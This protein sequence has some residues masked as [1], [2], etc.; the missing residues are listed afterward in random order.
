VE[1]ALKTAV[2]HEQIFRLGIGGHA[3]TMLAGVNALLVFWT[4]A[5]LVTFEWA[6]EVAVAKSH[7]ASLGEGW[8]WA[9]TLAMLMPPMIGLAGINRTT[10][11]WSAVL[12]MFAFA[13]FLLFGG[14]MTGRSVAPI[15]VEVAASFALLMSL[16]MAWGWRGVMRR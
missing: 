11:G 5:C 7:T 12:P 10:P 15:G 14:G 4:F 13:L 3:H 2:D 8:R 9:M 1:R 16:T 6:R